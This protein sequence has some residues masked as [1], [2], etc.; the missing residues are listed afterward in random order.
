LTF[1]RQEKQFTWCCFY[2]DESAE[3]A[4]NNTL[5][6]VW[7]LL[8]LLESGLSEVLSMTGTAKERDFGDCN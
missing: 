8:V 7:S 5:Y 1:R 3:S 4:H 2:I 6:F